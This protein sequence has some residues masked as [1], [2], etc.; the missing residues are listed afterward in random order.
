MPLKILSAD[1]VIK[2]PMKSTIVIPVYTTKITMTMNTNVWAMN[3]I[4]H[5]L[6]NICVEWLC[7]CVIVEWFAYRN[8][9]SP[10]HSVHTRQQTRIFFHLLSTELKDPA[11][12][13]GG[14]NQRHHKRASECLLP[15]SI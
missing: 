2:F 5:L 1:F 12:L 15:N 3:L 9:Q 7:L 10:G 6:K 13:L 4:T 14:F 11:A 8:P